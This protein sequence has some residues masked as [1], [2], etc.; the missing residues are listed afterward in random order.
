VTFQDAVPATG[1]A[2]RIEALV[3][4]YV[5]ADYR[6]E[7]AGDWPHFRVGALAPAIEDAF[8]GADCFGFLSAWNPHSVVRA[9]AENRAADESLRLRLLESGA[10]SRPAFSSAKDR[11]WR[12]PS[13]LVAGLPGAR[14]DALA[15]EFDQ[16]ATLWWPRGEAVRL[17]MYAI[18]PAGRWPF[19]DWVPATR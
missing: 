8:P 7:Q 14:Q 11:S 15:Q 9:D 18:R 10:S 2:A 19:V 1:D 16:L 3:R 17:R 5:D 12:E 13:W 6:W 4:A